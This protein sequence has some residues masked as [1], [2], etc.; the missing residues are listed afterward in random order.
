MKA[1]AQMDF[2][3]DLAISAEPQRVFN[4]LTKGVGA[5][6]G[7]PYLEEEAVGLELE[8]K[9]GGKF[10]ERWSHDPHSQEGALLG[11]V[12]AIRHPRLIRLQGSFGMGERLVQG[13]VTFEINRT[14][15]GSLL[16]FTHKA[17]GDFD[18]QIKNEYARGWHDLLGRLKFYLE[19]GEAEGITHGPSMHSYS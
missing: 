8:L 4:A 19:E 2:V 10:W 7:R 5:W 13:L 15:S 17:M 11:T 16:H 14:E 18:E 12:V 9:V 6:W 3:T 1:F